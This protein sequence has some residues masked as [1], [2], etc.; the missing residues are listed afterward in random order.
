[1]RLKKGWENFQQNEHKMI[2]LVA[3]DGIAYLADAKLAPT[4]QLT[5]SILQ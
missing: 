2:V 5:S 3:L 4:C 1:M